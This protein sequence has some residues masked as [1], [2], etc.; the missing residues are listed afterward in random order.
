[1]AG[2]IE[3]EIDG[4]GSEFDIIGVGSIEVEFKGRELGGG[5]LTAEDGLI[6][7]LEPGDF[8]GYGN[9]WIDGI[10][11]LVGNEDFGCVII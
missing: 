4:V 7:K 6:R 8:D 5:L 3:V 10:A 1:M 11:I 9:N 2:E